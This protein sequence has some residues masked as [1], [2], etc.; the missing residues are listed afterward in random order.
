MLDRVCFWSDSLPNN[1]G[2][3]KKGLSV[4]PLFQQ[5]CILKQVTFAP[6]ANHELRPRLLACVYSYNRELKSNTTSKE[7]RTSSENEIAFLQLFFN[8]SKSLRLKVVF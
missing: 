7:A 6:L 3:R 2:R 8:Y 4:L 5:S 1:S